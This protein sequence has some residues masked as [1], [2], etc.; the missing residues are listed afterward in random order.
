MKIL[1]IADEEAKYFYDFYRPGRLNE[2]D[3]I[4]SCGDL[5]ANYLEFLAT[6]AKCPVLY[7]RGNHDDR[8]SDSPP[9]GCI[10]IENKIYEHNGVRIFG[11]GGAYRYRPGANMYTEKQM[12]RRIWKAGIQLWR[13]KGFDILVTHAPAYGLNDLNNLSH[14]GF[15]SFLYLIEKYKPKYFIHGHVHMSY[16]YKMPRIFTYGDTTV[17]NAYEYCKLDYGEE[18]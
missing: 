7:V 16:D 12:K 13:K 2:F 18:S 5:K 8:L 11:L 10:C 14:R 17:V 15:E 6:M 9:G 4:I 3:L 1:A